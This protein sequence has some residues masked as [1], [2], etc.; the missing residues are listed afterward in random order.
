METRHVKLDYVNALSAKKDLLGAEI[1]LLQIVRK[2]KGY[3]GVRKR[4]LTVKNKLRLEIGKLRKQMDGLVNYLP[5]D[6]VKID[7]RKNKKKKVGDGGRN[8]D[9]ELGEIK[10][11]LAGLES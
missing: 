5:T 7:K 1:N 2:I 9:S 11:K 3:R 10:K 4:E 6:N 8:L